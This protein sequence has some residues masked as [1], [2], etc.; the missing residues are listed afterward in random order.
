MRAKRLACSSARSPVASIQWPSGKQGQAKRESTLRALLAA[1][2]PYQRDLERR[3]IVAAKVVMSGLNR[4]L[5]E[6]NEQGRRQSHPPEL[7]HRH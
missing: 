3:R 7:R 5:A 4:G 1:D 6:A 2:G